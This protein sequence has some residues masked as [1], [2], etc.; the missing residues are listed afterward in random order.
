MSNVKIKTDDGIELVFEHPRISR[1][2]KSSEVSLYYSSE[3]FE[4]ML[5]PMLACVKSFS[6]KLEEVSNI[7][8][9]P[10]SASIEFGLK[11]DLEGNF[12]VAKVGNET[13][14]KVTLTW[15]ENE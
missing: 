6:K 5:S 13:Y 2:V 11:L 3:T 12:V 1:P 8:N 15:N 7:S 14:F 9:H 4:K 10:N